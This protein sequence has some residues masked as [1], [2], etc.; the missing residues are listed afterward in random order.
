MI[1]LTWL[2][3][4]SWLIETKTM[5]ILLDP[6]FADNP[7]ATVG[8]D[9]FADCT[10]VLVSHGHFDHVGDVPAVA[11]KSG[12]QVVAI[13]EIAQWF[14]E[15]HQLTNVVGM[16]IGGQIE[17]PDGSLK[18]VPAIHSSVL[19]DGTYGGMP[20]GFVLNLGDRR[21]YFACDTAY[22]SD[23]KWYGGGVDIAVLPIG[24]LYTMGPHD[25]IE[26]IKIIEPKIVLPT[27]YGTWPPIEQN[28]AHWA[29]EVRAETDA[30]PVVLEVGESFEV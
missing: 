17:L 10:H 8:A 23:M 4:A 25:C 12:A 1:K 11:K 7:K 14:Q 9:D 6:F 19:P 15:K 21:I 18:M 16:N 2:S 20:A 24:D 29:A 22:F 13:F 30:K 26:A 27:H 28:A 5:R 3:H